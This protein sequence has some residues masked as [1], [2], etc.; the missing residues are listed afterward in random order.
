MLKAP[1]VR[2]TVG[3]REGFVAVSATTTTTRHYTPLR[4]IPL[5]YITLS[6]QLQLQLQLTTVHY[7][8]D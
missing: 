1:H 6:L 3:K 5:H 8:K 7:T 4:S 2:T